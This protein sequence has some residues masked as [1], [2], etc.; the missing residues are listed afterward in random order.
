MQRVKVVI[1][2]ADSVLNPVS[3]LSRAPLPSIGHGVRTVT[4]NSPAGT[5]PLPAHHRRFVKFRAYTQVIRHASSASNGSSLQRT[6]LYELH[7]ARNGKMV[8]FAGY[9]MPVQYDDLGVGESH[10]WTREKA[11]LFD[12]GHM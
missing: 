4:R 12:V 2:A 5:T 6:P 7:V 1:A 8:P 11:S 3:I 9:S 10:K